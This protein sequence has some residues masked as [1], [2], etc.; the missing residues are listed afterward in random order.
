MMTYTNLFGPVFEVERE[1][2]PLDRHKRECFTLV[3]LSDA[4]YL[5]WFKLWFYTSASYTNL[6]LLPQA[7][8]F[9]E[10]LTQDVAIGGKIDM[11]WTFQTY[12]MRENVKQRYKHTIV[13]N[14]YVPFFRQDL[15][16]LQRVKIVLELERIR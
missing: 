6:H 16:W 7:L 5:A 4:R 9:E 2:V 1:E 11:Y 14:V 12:R 15:M 3:N 13:I 10:L 8:I